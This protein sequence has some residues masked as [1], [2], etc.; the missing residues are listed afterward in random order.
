MKQTTRIVSGVES[1]RIFARRAP[2]NDFPVPG[3][4][5]ADSIL[6]RGAFVKD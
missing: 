3:F 6:V 5:N 1:C 2:M 4:V